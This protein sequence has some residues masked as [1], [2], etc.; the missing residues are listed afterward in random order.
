MCQK[1]ALAEGFYIAGWVSGEDRRACAEHGHAEHD[2]C[3]DCVTR[4]K[5]ALKEKADR[6]EYDRMQ[7]LHKR[8]GGR[9][10]RARAVF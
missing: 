5:A 8:F 7:A 2:V 4:F 10:K 3:E 6:A 1:A 9:K